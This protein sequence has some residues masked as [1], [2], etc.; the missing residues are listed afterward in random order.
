M[1][2]PHPRPPELAVIARRECEG[3]TERCLVTLDVG[4]L[5]S[6]LETVRLRCSR[7]MTSLR[8]TAAAW[9]LAAACVLVAVLAFGCT[10]DSARVPTATPSGCSPP[11]S[12]LIG[13]F[14][15][16][17]DPTYR[18]GMLRPATWGVVDLGFG[19]GFILPEPRRMS[20]TAA[21]FAAVPSPPSG[22]IAQQKLFRDHPTLSGWTGAVERPGRA[23][24]SRCC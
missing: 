11:R 10:G 20:L 9:Q 3:T 24:T 7:R 18:F 5:R 12:P 4:P 8:R 16:H 6:M 1:A 22:A 2:R 19:R 15:W 17:V 13:S 21:N 23:R 14:V